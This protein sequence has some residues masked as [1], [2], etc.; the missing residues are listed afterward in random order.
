[1]I[2]L[3]FRPNFTLLNGKKVKNLYGIKFSWIT[4]Y[5]IRYNSNKKETN[6]YINIMIFTR[7][8][9]FFFIFYPR[10]D[11]INTYYIPICIYL[12]HNTKM[13]VC[14]SKQQQQK[15]REQTYCNQFSMFVKVTYFLL[16][17]LL[18]FIIFNT[19]KVP[20]SNLIY[21]IIA[22]DNNNI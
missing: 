19:F 12:Q 22:R 5:E 16:L 8:S 13:Y 7:T 18:Y 1:M 9:V 3:F 20:I 10:F 6:D 11:I 15:K 17:L 21:C 4:I 14:H 2:E